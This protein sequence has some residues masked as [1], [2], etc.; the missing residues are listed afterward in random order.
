MYFVV[1]CNVKAGDACIEGI[2]LVKHNR[3]LG[4]TW[5]AH[6]FQPRKYGQSAI[7]G[8]YDQYGNIWPHDCHMNSAV[9]YAVAQAFR[10]GKIAASI[11][12]VPHK[13][14]LYLQLYCLHVHKKQHAFP[15]LTVAASHA[16]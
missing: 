8:G 3:W 2:Y 14:E 1:R 4:D 13:A 16:P 6:I 5:H 11:V 10:A 9:V 15:M 12:C 7:V